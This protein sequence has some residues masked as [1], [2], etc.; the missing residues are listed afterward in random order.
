MSDVNASDPGAAPQA[1]APAAPTAVASDAPASD[2]PAPVEAAKSAATEDVQAPASEQAPAA[3]PSVA[4]PADDPARRRDKTVGT[5]IVVVA[6]ILSLGISLWAK[7][8]SRP[9]V[10]DPPRPPTTEGVVGFPSKVDAIATLKAARELTKRPL[11]RQIIFDG[12][13]SNGTNDVSGGAG[14]RVRYVF[15]SPPGHGAQPPR[16]PGTLPRQHYCGKQ[17]VQIRKAGLAAD[18]DRADSPCPTRHAE[19][20]PDPQ[21]SLKSIWQA[22][23]KRGVPADRL[24]KIEYYRAQAGPAWRFELVGGKQKF[25]LHGDCQRELNPSEAQNL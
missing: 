22:A 15:Q 9:E 18:T 2:A 16:E 6:F 11:L 14:A 8:I 7:H 20:L 23:E 17:T 19:P 13:A 12:V 10:A 21:C 1:A 24:A 5:V 4:P 25:T 3:R